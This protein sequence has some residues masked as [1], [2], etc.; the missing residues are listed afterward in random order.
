MGHNYVLDGHGRIA[1]LSEMR[2]QGYDLPI[3]PVVY[4]DAR[5]E[6]EAKIKLLQQNS[7]YGTITEEGF[8]EFIG[9]M[10]I[11]MGELAL[12]EIKLPDGTVEV[13]YRE[14]TELIL[15][16]ENETQAE[17]LYGEFKERGIKCR[18]STL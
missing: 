1:A 14:K 12:S 2:R 13:K 9:D 3:F 4:I 15:E 5:D 16:C 6:E 8:A 7:H 10:V 11:D 18:I 17:E